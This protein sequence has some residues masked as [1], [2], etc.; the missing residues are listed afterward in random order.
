MQAE[1]LPQ[2]RPVKRR[3]RSSGSQSSERL[4]NGMFGTIIPQFLPPQMTQ[5][6]KSLTT[7]RFLSN[8]KLRW[9]W[10]LT[11]PWQMKSS[12]WWRSAQ[13]L[14][15]KQKGWLMFTSTCGKPTWRNT[16]RPK[17]LERKIVFLEIQTGGL[18]KTT[19]FY[20]ASV[21]IE[22]QTCMT[23]AKLSS[24]S[25]KVFLISLKILT[26]FTNFYHCHK[27][28]QHIFEPRWNHV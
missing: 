25:V 24:Q 7:D 26:D 10:L 27:T 14:S 22:R 19:I 17:K 21:P 18:K 5:V 15:H 1:S 9:P 6:I 20:V 16:E 28:L 4:E 13:L 23:V 2:R 8:R 3:R 12:S 11:L